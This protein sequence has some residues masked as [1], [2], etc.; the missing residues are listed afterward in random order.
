M[1]KF[2]ELKELKS[3]PA[4]V[5]VLAFVIMSFVVRGVGGTNASSRYATMQAMADEHSFAIDNY[6]GWSEDWSPSPNGKKYSNKAPGPMLLGFP[7]FFVL[8]RVS[9]L[10]GERKYRS[11]GKVDHFFGPSFQG[12]FSFFM[13]V[14]PF[15]LFTLYLG[16]KWKVDNLKWRFFVLPFLFGNTAVLF[17]NSYFGHGMAALFFA[18]AIFFSLEKRYFLVGIFFGF[19]LLSDYSAVISFPFIFLALIYKERRKISNLAPFFYGGIFPGFLWCWY[20]WVAF[21][22]P[23]LTSVSFP[24]PLFVFH[25]DK[26]YLGGMFKF[27]PDWKILFELTLGSY[28]GLL[29]TQPW[30]ILISG[31]AIIKFKKIELV[32]VLLVLNLLASLWMNSTFW[33]WH[34]GS[35]AGPRYL[36]YLMLA[37][38]FILYYCHDNFSPAFLKL[39]WAAVIISLIFRA[40]VYATTVLAPLEP[41]WT[42]Q[43]KTIFEV[44]T[45]KSIFRLMLTYILLIGG[46]FIANYQRDH[47]KR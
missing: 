26:A 18:M 31:W 7:L 12:L 40:Q 5:W 28:R 11:D 9:K 33:G 45:G 20:H 1:P 29:F 38:C 39:V 41:L 42:W 21:G 46:W 23:F 15:A 10:S 16:F 34:A 6:L 19:A 43:W 37:L 4:L 44:D 8:D 3:N 27:F 2:L 24:N 30:L 25:E 22:S 36:S 47:L 13:Q 35:S 17:M 14:L 32:F